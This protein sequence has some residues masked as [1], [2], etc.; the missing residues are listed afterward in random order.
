MKRIFQDSSQD[1][2]YFPAGSSPAPKVKLTSFRFGKP[3]VSLSRSKPTAQ[4]QREF[5]QR[6][7]FNF[8]NPVA[9]VGV[10]AK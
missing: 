6:Q 1:N 7:K 9:I 4:R 10:S 8:L 2:L 3:T 5:R